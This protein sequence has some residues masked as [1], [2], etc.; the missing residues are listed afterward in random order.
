MNAQV[1][2]FSISVSYMKKKNPRKDHILLSGPHPFTPLFRTI[3]EDSLGIT[4][5]FQMPALLTSPLFYK[6]YT[7]V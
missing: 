2:L 7:C 6:V 1:V 4:T 5:I 3:K